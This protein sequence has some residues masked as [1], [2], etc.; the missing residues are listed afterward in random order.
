MQSSINA[1]C[2]LRI[3]NDWNR[4][5]NS[6]N[7]TSL[8]SD[9]KLLE[10]KSKI[11]T[12]SFITSWIIP[13]IFGIVA[14]FFTELKEPKIVTEADSKI[15]WI[16][17]FPCTIVYIGLRLIYFILCYYYLFKLLKELK[18]ST[19]NLNLGELYNEYMSSFKKYFIGMTLLFLIFMSYST[20]NIIKQI[21]QKI[22]DRWIYLIIVIGDV[23]FHPIVVILFIINKEKWKQIKGLC[24]NQNDFINVN[25]VT[26]SEDS[27]E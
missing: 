22:I 17:S 21:N 4:N 14:I 7:R 5:F 3:N 10:L 15:C 13:I 2:L 23:F 16:T 24:K 19:L 18:K 12:T 9:S 26:E 1:Y 6:Y 20:S 8:A 11:F 25:I 27:I